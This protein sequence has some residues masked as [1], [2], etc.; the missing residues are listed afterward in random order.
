MPPLVEIEAVSYSYPNRS[1]LSQRRSYP[2]PPAVS[3]V[4][5][6][7]PKGKTVVVIGESGCGKTTL[8]K[9]L[10]RFFDPTAGDIVF[11]GVDLLK[12]RGG[13]L[14]AFRAKLQMVYQDPYLSL[15]P[16]MRVGQILEEPL[17]IH[18]REGTRAGRS[19]KIEEVIARVGLAAS[20][21]ERFPHMF[22]GGQ[23]QRISIARAL[24]LEP[25]LLVLDE[26]TSALDV[27]IQAKLLKMLLT[28]QEDLSLTYLF[29]THD[30]RVAQLMGDYVVV[31]Y[32]GRVVEIGPVGD[33]FSDPKHPYTRE[34]I[35]AAPVAD[36]ERRISDVVEA[37]EGLRMDDGFERPGC[38][39]ADR[40]PMKLGEVCETT[41]PRAVT[42]GRWWETACHAYTRPAM[43]SDF[44]S[45]SSEG[46]TRE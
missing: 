4:S 30:M 21:L 28:L 39:F 5:F 25:D 27:S 32:L 2:V 31:M 6:D 17:I 26:P 15:D 11:D 18:R 42:V 3:E 7:I 43:I 23:R 8:G 38:S 16:R 10:M 22:S 44:G 20:D 46:P 33:V 36:P 37:R 34:L 29:I 35:A 41:V 9:L 19:K 13:A 24:I 14:R 12:L 40:C 45:T 1:G